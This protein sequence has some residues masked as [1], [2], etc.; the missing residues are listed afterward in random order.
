[1][2]L[3]NRNMFDTRSDDGK[4]DGAS[5]RCS[6]THHANVKQETP[7]VSA[8]NHFSHLLSSRQSPSTLSSSSSSRIYKHHWKS[9]VIAICIAI[10]CQGL[11]MAVSETFLPGKKKA[12]INSWKTR[13]F[14]PLYFYMD[15]YSY[16]S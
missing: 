16:S 8:M 14:F 10:S 11:P 13:I 7:T 12:Q 3:P 4:D 1:M 9:W 6:F 2:Q 5:H 15:L